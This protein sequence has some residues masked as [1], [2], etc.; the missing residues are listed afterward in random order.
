MASVEQMRV[1]IKP[2]CGKNGLSS[3]FVSQEGQR[4][5]IDLLL[6]KAEGEYTWYNLLSDLWRRAAG[7]KGV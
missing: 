3:Q 1:Q 6:V 7:L 4:E 5:L 2:T